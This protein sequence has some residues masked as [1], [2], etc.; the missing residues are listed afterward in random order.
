M[1]GYSLTDTHME[2]ALFGTHGKW[3]MQFL[4]SSDTLE[5]LSIFCAN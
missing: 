4:Y 1:E 2:A 3:P 5:V